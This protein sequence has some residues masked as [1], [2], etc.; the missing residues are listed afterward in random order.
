MSANSNGRQKGAMIGVGRK[1]YEDARYMN[2][3]VIRS[4]GGRIC[5]RRIDINVDQ[6]GSRP[7][8][9]NL[10]AMATCSPNLRLAR[11]CIEG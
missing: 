8:Y 7:I 2:K 4:S 3:L 11:L 10:S 1:L 9:D 5:V 6:R